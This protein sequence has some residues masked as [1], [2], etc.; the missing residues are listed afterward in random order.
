MK[1]EI[2]EIVK[3]IEANGFTV[4]GG[5]NRHYKVKN[6][7]GVTVAVLPSTPGQGRWRQNALAD[8]KR[9]GIIE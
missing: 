8:L 2:R 7:D 5:G 1:K 6:A 4:E 3:L 9:K